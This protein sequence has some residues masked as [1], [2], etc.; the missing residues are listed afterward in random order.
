MDL[1]AVAVTRPYYFRSWRTMTF[2]I[3]YTQTNKEIFVIKCFGFRLVKIIIYLKKFVIDLIVFRQNCI[4]LQATRIS[5]FCTSALTLTSWRKRE[6]MKEN[7]NIEIKTKHENIF[8][9]AWFTVAT[10]FATER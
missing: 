3:F 5:S 2:A 6:K 8:I 4:P 7:K 10:T 1:S 9:F